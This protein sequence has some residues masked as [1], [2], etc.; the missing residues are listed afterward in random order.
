V[1][2]MINSDNP[3]IVQTFA[4]QVNLGSSRDIGNT[5]GGSGHE[6]FNRELR[7]HIGHP[8]SKILLSNG[9]VRDLSDMSAAHR[10]TNNKLKAS[11]ANSKK[12]RTLGLHQAT[13]AA[14]AQAKTGHSVPSDVARPS[15]VAAAAAIVTQQYTPAQVAGNFS[16]PGGSQRQYSAAPAGS[17]NYAFSLRAPQPV[18]EPMA[19][20]PPP[21]GA[22][23]KKLPVAP[24]PPASGAPAKKPPI[25]T[26]AAHQYSN[27]SALGALFG[28]VPSE[29]GN[30]SMAATIRNPIFW[31]GD[32]E[33]CW[34]SKGCTGVDGGTVEDSPQ[35]AITFLSSPPTDMLLR[36]RSRAVR[37][38]RLPGVH[39]VDTSA[40]EK[41]PRSQQAHRVY[42]HMNSLSAENQRL[43]MVDVMSEAPSINS[44]RMLNSLDSVFQPVPPPVPNEVIDLFGAD[45]TSPLK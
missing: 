43:I 1:A 36:T 4:D 8:T 2:G 31:G 28:S 11:S 37:E 41:H 27:N 23:A 24:K 19:N 18:T 15:N 16:K 25:A 6:A 35:G 44:E 40:T 17:G 38:Q 13:G 34:E 29:H 7:W 45:D 3:K 20:K 10:K 39:N 33:T 32:D 9:D 30:Q 21:P 12:Q 5:W 22:L 14:S 26:P 42:R